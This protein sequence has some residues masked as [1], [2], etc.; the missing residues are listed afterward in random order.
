MTESIFLGVVQ[1]LTEFLPVSSDGHLTLAQTLFDVAH[2]SLALDVALHA[3]TLLAMI[4]FFRKDILRIIIGVLSKEAT[5]ER[6][7][8]RKRAVFVIVAT[9][10]TAIVG[11]SL[12][13]YV[14]ASVAS[15]GPVAFGFLVTAAFLAGGEWKLLKGGP[16]RPLR[17]IPLWHL[18][19]LGLVQGAAVWPGWSRSGSTIAVALLLGWKWEEAGRFS[20]VIAIPA[21][22]GALLLLSGDIAE[23]DPT[24]AIAGATTAFFVGLLS[25]WLLMRFLAAKKLWPFAL[26]TF[27]LGIFALSQVF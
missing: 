15:F 10:F 20:F 13:A 4:V 1:G 17:S 2:A 11:F 12:K 26:Y 25:L 8:E 9:V 21:T 14:E 22:F 3:G 18:I 6:A 5:P 19:V 23:I 16:G 27:A 24:Q 7:E